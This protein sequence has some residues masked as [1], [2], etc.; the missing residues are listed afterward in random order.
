MFGL[1]GIYVEVMKDVTFRALP[2]N[3]KEISSM[4]TGIKSSALLTGAR[5]QK[6]RDINAVKDTISRWEP[7]SMSVP[8]SR[9][10]RSIP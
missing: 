2:L 1:G 3:Q 9:T 4:I 6:P 7:F 8:E 10:S 5:G